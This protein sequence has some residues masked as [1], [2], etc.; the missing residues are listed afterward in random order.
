MPAI[1]DNE[2][3]PSISQADGLATLPF[4]PVTRSHIMHC[5][6]HYWHPK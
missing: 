4:P 1:I 5:S 6:Y 3:A 2:S